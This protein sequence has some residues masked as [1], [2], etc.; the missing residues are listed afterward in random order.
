MD[1]VKMLKLI[2]KYGDDTRGKSDLEMR[3][4]LVLM[5]M[6]S[7]K[8]VRNLETLPHLGLLLYNGWCKICFSLAS[9]HVYRL[10]GPPDLFIQAIPQGG[11]MRMGSTF[12]RLCS[13]DERT[14]CSKA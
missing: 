14:C 7:P 9:T 11:N 13:S 1:E 12:R 6:H 2:L 4:I 3:I 10:V 8:K 5:G